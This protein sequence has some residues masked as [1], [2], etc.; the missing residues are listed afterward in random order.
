[1]K[2]Y[3]FIYENGMTLKTYI[4]ENKEKIE[5]QHVLLTLNTKYETS[6]KVN[7]IIEIDSEKLNI[8]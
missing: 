3:Y 4:S 2:L 7:S 5:K 1:M 8:I 6:K